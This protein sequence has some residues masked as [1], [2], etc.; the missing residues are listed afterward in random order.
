MEGLIEG[1]GGP[2]TF[3]AT[4]ANGGSPRAP[5]AS[6]NIMGSWNWTAAC[7]GSTPSGRFEILNQR[8]DGA[9]S[10]VFSNATSA[11]TG[12]ID[13]RQQGLFLDFRRSIPGAGEQRW[14]GGLAAS[15]GALTME[16]RIEGVGGPCSFSAVMGR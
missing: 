7:N 15:G 2:C 1:P 9:I 14:T 10:G 12:T 4:T 8:R 13:G 11:D 5:G 6:T 16:G 3:S